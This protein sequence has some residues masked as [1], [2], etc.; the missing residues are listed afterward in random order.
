MLAYHKRLAPLAWLQW[1]DIKQ[2]TDNAAV[3]QPGPAGSGGG[4]APRA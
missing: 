2:L 3:G 1:L 4:G